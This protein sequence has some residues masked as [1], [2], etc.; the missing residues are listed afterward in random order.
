[1]TVSNTRGAAPRIADDVVYREH[2]GA[3]VLTS[4]SAGGFLR[5]DDV[6]REIWT[7]LADGLD[8]DGIVAR[9]TAQ[10]DVSAEACREDVEA[11]LADLAGRGLVVSG[12]AVR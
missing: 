7:A 2:E 5:L 10:Y 12:E 1:M 6:G 9:L 3:L 4:L 8:V 11:F